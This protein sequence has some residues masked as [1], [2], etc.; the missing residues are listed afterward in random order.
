MMVGMM[1]MTNRVI[2]RIEVVMVIV[3]FIKLRCLLSDEKKRVGAAMVKK[4]VPVNIVSG[5]R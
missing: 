5:P 3:L 2:R 4:R 1:R